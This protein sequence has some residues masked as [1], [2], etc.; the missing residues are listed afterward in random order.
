MSWTTPNSKLTDAE[1]I[2]IN[3]LGERKVIK[4]K[5]PKP[6]RQYYPQNIKIDFML[7][8]EEWQAKYGKK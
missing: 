1:K 7:S 5:A 2:A 8:E 3:N 4:K 6:P